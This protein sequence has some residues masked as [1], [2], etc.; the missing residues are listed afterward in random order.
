MNRKY[1]PIGERDC[2]NSPLGSSSWPPGIWKQKKKFNS[3]DNNKNT[4]KKKKEKKKLT[5]YC[6]CECYMST[7]S[8]YSIS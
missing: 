6:K 1:M 7:K 3:S 5:I 2:P 8:S 4:T